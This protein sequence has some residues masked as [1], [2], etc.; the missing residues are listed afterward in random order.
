MSGI[1]SP[2]ALADSWFT[3][4]DQNIE[5]AIHDKAGNAIDTT[6]W[7]TQFRMAT[8]Q[9]GASVLTKSGSQILT[10]RII[11]TFNAADTVGLAAKTYWYALSRLDAGVNQVLA[12]GDAVLQARVV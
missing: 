2:I 10:S 7:T 5:W 12:F 11:V 3:G 4:E 8:A 6:G 1:N 9:G